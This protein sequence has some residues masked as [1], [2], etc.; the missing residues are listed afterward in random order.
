MKQVS[1]IIGNDNGNSEH[2]F[3]VNGKSINQP[4]VFARVRRL[5]NLEELNKDFILKN[6]HSKLI[7]TI[8]S[9]ELNNGAAMSYYIGNYACE[10]GR[11]LNNITVGA[12]NSKINSE[13]PLVNTLAQVAASAVKEMPNESEIEVTVDMTTALPVTQYSKENAKTFANKFLN[14][15]HRVTVHLGEQNV[16]TYIDFNY[17]KVLPEG[18]T[19]IFFLQEIQARMKKYEEEK[20][21]LK[22]EELKKLEEEHKMH[23]AILGTYM[24]DY[25]LTVEDLDFSNKK[26]LH[27]AIGEGTTEYPLTEGINFNPNFIKGTNNGV[28]HAINKVLQE[29]MKEKSLI[30]FARQDYSNILKDKSHKYHTDAVDY[31]MDA[32]EDEAFIILDNVKQEIGKANND[33]DIICVYGGGS[34]LMREFLYEELKKFAEAVQVQ[35]MY[36]PEPYAVTAE[37]QGMYAFTKSK[38]FDTLKKMYIQHQSGN[39][40]QK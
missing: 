22:G 34:I 12:D 8:E 28:G 38:I 24:K 21:A 1:L 23:M 37:A 25:G 32:L 35:I 20:V 18:V 40:S 14:A 15:Q 39:N 13:V 16:T 27:V 6:L 33:V 11:A 19:T 4:N 17:V 10:S 3:I 36:I 29:F 31:V 9:P 26:I 7:V 30:K 5:P 2:D